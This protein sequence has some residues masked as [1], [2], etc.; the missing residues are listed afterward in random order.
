M[1]AKKAKFN[2][3]LSQK[4]YIGSLV[5]FCMHSLELFKIE[6]LQYL[7]TTVAKVLDFLPL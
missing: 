5:W 1:L 2:L 7:Y 4:L 3:N 6:Q